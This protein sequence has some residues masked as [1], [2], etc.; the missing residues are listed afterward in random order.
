MIVIEIPRLPISANQAWR[1]FR[2]RMITSKE[3]KAWLTEVEKH[4]PDG[5]PDWSGPFTRLSVEI[6]LHSPEWFTKK[7]VRK[8][9]LDNYIKVLL[10][11]VFKHLLVDDSAIFGLKATKVSGLEKTIIRIGHWDVS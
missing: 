6:E 5:I 1:T 10:D 8:R 11:S 2:G 7:G 3:Y 9:D 4:I